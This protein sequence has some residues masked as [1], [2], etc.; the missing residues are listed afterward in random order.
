MSFFDT[1]KKLLYPRG[2]SSRTVLAGRMAG[3]DRD[4]YAAGCV[5]VDRGASDTWSRCRRRLKAQKTL[6]RYALLAM[7]HLFNRTEDC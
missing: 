2:R 3:Q 1:R 4:L 6:Q 5:A 7:R